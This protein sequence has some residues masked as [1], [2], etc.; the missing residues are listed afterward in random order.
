MC[1]LMIDAHLY[2]AMSLAMAI[3]GRE[4]SPDDFHTTTSRKPRALLSRNAV[5]LSLCHA[6]RPDSAA[7]ADHG[8]VEVQH[9]PENPPAAAGHGRRAAAAEGDETG[10]G[11]PHHLRLQPPDGSSDPQAGERGRWGPWGLLERGRGQPHGWVCGPTA[12]LSG[13]M[14]D[15]TPRRRSAAFETKGCLIAV[16]KEAPARAQ[17]AAKSR[18]GLRLGIPSMKQP[19]PHPG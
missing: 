12:F 3:W 16:G 18:L 5:P 1:F 8:P 11:V 14:D 9:P 2:L 17:K 4:Q 13:T 19:Q 15:F 6:R 10:P 7:G